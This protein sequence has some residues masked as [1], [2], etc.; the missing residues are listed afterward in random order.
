[1]ADTSLQ[2]R[3]W[4][5]YVQDDTILLFEIDEDDQYIAPELDVTDGIKFEFVTGDNVFV[6]SNGFADDTSPTESSIL[7]CRDSVI[8][9][10]LCFVRSKIA[11]DVDKDQAMAEYWQ[12]KFTKE[13][14]RAQSAMGTR[15][16]V[17]IPSSPYAIR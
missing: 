16:S 2:T 11:E 5:Y 13:Y 9:A 1:M 6:D 12:D 8:P 15:P 17:A 3:N 14:L 10:I 4:A 7:N